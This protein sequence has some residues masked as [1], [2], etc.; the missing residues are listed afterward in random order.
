GTVALVSAFNNENEEFTQQ[1]LG[2]G[3]APVLDGQ[4]TSVSI[5]LTKKGAKILWESFKTNTPN[6]TFSFNMEY[7]GY[8]APIKAMVS[9]EWEKIYEHKNFQ[10]GVATPVL[11]AEVDVA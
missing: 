4:K 5:Q 10:A 7:E 3:P 9:F 1:V 2:L 8:S 11:S 6:I